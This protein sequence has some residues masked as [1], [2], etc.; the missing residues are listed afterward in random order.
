MQLICLAAGRPSYY[1]SPSMYYGDFTVK[2]ETGFAYA[3]LPGLE[4]LRTPPRPSAKTLF[5][6]GGTVQFK[7]NSSP[8]ASELLFI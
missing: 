8:A 1:C 3:E 6:K 4:G 2:V 7:Y 5:K